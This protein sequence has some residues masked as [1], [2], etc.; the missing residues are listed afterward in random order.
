MRGVLALF[1][2]V[3][4][5]AF[6][7]P[8]TAAGNDD[9][10]PCDSVSIVSLGMYPDPLADGN[11]VTEWNLRVHSD[12]EKTCRVPIRI[13]ELERNVVAAETSALIETGTNDLKLGSMPDYRLTGETRCFNV[14][15]TA[16]E[17]RTKPEAPQTFCAL[18]IDNWWSM[19]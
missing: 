19:R 6:V 5:E 14:I 13:V 17:T 7:T 2:I 3:A 18:H 4:A 9:V 15:W 8:R 11:K 1:F 10:R 12:G 16:A